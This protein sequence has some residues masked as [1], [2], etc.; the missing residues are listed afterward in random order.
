[1]A[2]LNDAVIPSGSTILVTGVNGFVGSHIANDLLNHGYKVR[3]T[4][5]D[6]HRHTWLIEL[7]TERYGDGKFELVVV[8]DMAEASAFDNAIKGVAGVAH[9]AAHVTMQNDLHA[10]SKANI[11]GTLNALEAAAKEPSVL[12]FVF[13]STSLAVRQNEEFEDLRPVAAD[14]YNETAIELAKSLPDSQTQM[15]K[16]LTVYAAAKAE[17]EKALWGWVQQN[18]PRFVVNSVIPPGILGRPIS[19]QHQ[20]YPSFSGFLVNF[21]KREP[22]L[23]DVL[24]RFYFTSVQDIARLHVAGLIHPKAE[25]RRIFAFG[26]T[27]TV[28]DVLAIFK[29][30]CPDRRFP[31]YIPGLDHNL[32]LIEPRSEAEALLR[33]LGRPGFDSLAEA[34]KQTISELI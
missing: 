27:C 32:A 28:N 11:S 9:V 19:V 12:R 21:F 23:L 10:V 3:G 22:G 14:E 1:M 7:F 15:E 26:G 29:D 30:M 18:K 16:G 20:G 2:L 5:R 4:V 8:K 13:T 25:S 17:T 34:V 6:I 33:D 31:D 24:H